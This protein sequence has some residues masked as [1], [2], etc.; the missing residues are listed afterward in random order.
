MEKEEELSEEEI[1]RLKEII[2]QTYGTKKEDII[3]N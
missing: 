1:E 2:T 3:I